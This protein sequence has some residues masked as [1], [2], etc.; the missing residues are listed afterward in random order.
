MNAWFRRLAVELVIAVGGLSAVGCSSEAPGDGVAPGESASSAAGAGAASPRAQCEACESM[1]EGA[2]NNE[3][4]AQIL[5]CFNDSACQA[6]HACI[7]IEPCEVDTRAGA[8]CKLNC[9]AQTIASQA[10][11]DLYRLYDQCVYCKT[12]KGLCDTEAYCAVFEPG[13][14][15][16]CGE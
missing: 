10:S 3:C 4:L 7:E 11:I 16:T 1:A 8:C 15:S 9:V 12:C 14:S 5:D 2:P 13:G 6:I